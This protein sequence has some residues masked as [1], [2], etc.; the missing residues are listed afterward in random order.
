M[1]NIWLNISQTLISLLVIGLIFLQPGNDNESRGNFFS[2]TKTNKRGWEK[3]IFQLTLFLVSTF[4][5]LNL[6][7][8][9]S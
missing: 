4:A 2:S 3:V 9:L 7:V 1:T 6:I 5:V 8:S